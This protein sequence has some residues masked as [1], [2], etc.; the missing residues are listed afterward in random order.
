MLVYA[1][2]SELSTWMGE[3]AS[4]NAIPLLRA[5]SVLVADATKSDIYD[6]AANGKPKDDDLL[7]ALRDAACAQAEMWSAAGLDPIKGPG[8]QKQRLTTSS[9]DGASLGFDAY[10]T[11]PARQAALTGLCDRALLI[12]RNAGLASSQVLSW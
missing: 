8:G 3:P 5:A 7:E 4:D 10:L 11:E 6:V 1:T 9:I 2:P 12:L